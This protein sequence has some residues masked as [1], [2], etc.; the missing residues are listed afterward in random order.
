MNSSSRH[1]ATAAAS[2]AVFAVLVSGV[3]LALAAPP[4]LAHARLTGSEPSAGAT[5]DDAPDEVVLTFNEEIEADFNQA[6]VRGPG[7]DRV[8]A[9]AAEGEGDQVRVPVQALSV[10]GT[11]AV[12]FRVISADGHPVEG[13]F[14]FELTDQAVATGDLPPE[15]TVE[16]DQ[17]P[18]TEAPVGD[19]AESPPPLA[20]DASTDQRDGFP[21]AAVAIVLLLALGGLAFVA[22]LRRSARTDEPPA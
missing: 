6:Q 22:T 12:V 15:S 2:S 5:L 13:D 20:E 11:Y 1:P 16:P 21:F 7:G 8:D 10:P 4:A 14:E 19:G 9:G 18:A 17:E 3:L